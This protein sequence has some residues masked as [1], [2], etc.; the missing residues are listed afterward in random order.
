MLKQWLHWFS[1]Q[2]PKLVEACWILSMWTWISIVSVFTVKIWFTF[3]M[4][5]LPY[6]PGF[7]HARVKNIFLQNMLEYYCRFSTEFQVW[8]SHRFSYISP[9]IIKP[10]FFQVY[11]RYE[12]FY[13]T[14]HSYSF[15]LDCLHH[16]LKVNILELL[17]L[18]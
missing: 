3:C 9:K 13:I 14:D 17:T 18:C 16:S 8:L 6:L 5:Q 12:V 1:I 4:P 15:L 7:I 11:F 2:K 10:L